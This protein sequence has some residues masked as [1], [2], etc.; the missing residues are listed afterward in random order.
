MYDYSTYDEKAAYDRRRHRRSSSGASKSSA[1]S[2]SSSGSSAS[3]YSSDS[4]YEETKPP[5]YA[6]L[7]Y[8]SFEDKVLPVVPKRRVRF[9]LDPP[10]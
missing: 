10:L 2:R 3:T 6:D 8:N 1:M 4:T 7:Y 5:P 9:A